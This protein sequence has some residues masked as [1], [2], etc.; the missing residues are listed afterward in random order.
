MFST[1]FR[2]TTIAFMVM[3]AIMSGYTTSVKAECYTPVLGVASAGIEHTA[4]LVNFGGDVHVLVVDSY[5]GELC[6]SYD[7]KVISDN[8]ATRI[9]EDDMSNVAWSKGNLSFWYESKPYVVSAAYEDMLIARDGMYIAGDS[10]MWYASEYNQY[11]YDDAVLSPVY[12]VALP[13]VSN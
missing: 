13:V 12:R 6:Y 4:L 11:I 10:A 1:L 8:Y 2:R 7:S 5:N 9:T 3:F